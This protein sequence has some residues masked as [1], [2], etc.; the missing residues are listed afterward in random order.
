[1]TA[2]R[3]PAVLDLLRAWDAPGQQ[4]LRG[5]YVAFVAAHGD[6]ALRRE[7]G[8]Q[9]LTASCVVLSDD[10]THVLL[11]YHRKGRFWV[12]LGGHVEDD[13]ATLAAAALRE[14]REESG[15]T[16]LRLASGAPSDVDR[17]DLAA[18]FGTC[19]THWDVAFVAV[20]SPDAPV[21]VSDESED[22]RWFP[23]D[24]L[25]SDAPDNLPG[26]VARAVA[27]ARL[28]ARSSSGPLPAAGADGR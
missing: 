20:A 18:A 19:R 27:R 8:A 21:V 14:A 22:V 26:R 11:C 2:D 13:D 17:H 28:S 7:G 9:H 16:S 1:M 12:Q 24:A 5:E 3:H 15:L 10:L 6:A 4:D 25:P 23:V